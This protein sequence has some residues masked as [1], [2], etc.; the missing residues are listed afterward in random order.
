[1][2]TDEYEISLAREI[3]VC[4]GVIKQTEKQLTRRQQRFGMDLPQAQKAAAAG[5]QA[6]DGKEL[7]DWQEDVEA[8]RQWQQRL[9]Q[10]REA[11]AVMRVSAPRL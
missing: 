3:N 6:I 9:E 7:V 10:Y 8:L 11:L 1:M 2:H 4:K 5:L